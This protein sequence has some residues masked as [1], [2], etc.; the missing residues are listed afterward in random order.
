[1]FSIY[2][3]TKERELYIQQCKSM[4]GAVVYSQHAINCWKDQGYIN[5]D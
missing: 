2:N 5:V 3:V 4:G 1:M